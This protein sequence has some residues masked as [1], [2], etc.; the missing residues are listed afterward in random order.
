[1]TEQQNQE[2]AKSFEPNAIE[3]RWYPVW[4]K[5]GYFRAGLDP[6]K[7]AFSIQLTPPNI[8]GI[9]HMG[10]A[11]NQTVSSKSRASSAAR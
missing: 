5:R 3:S 6:K 10:H 7:P 9:L 1:M 2:L 11:F 4:E 8:T